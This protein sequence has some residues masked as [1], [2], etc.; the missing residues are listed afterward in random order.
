M[1]GDAHNHRGT[2][3]SRPPLVAHVWTDYVP[4]SFVEPHSHM[5]S[6]EPRF[7]SVNLVA[8]LWDNGKVIDAHT[9]WMFR[10][11]C[12]NLVA[13]TLLF[14]VYRRATTF[15]RRIRFREFVLEKASGFGASLIHSHFGTTGCKLNRLIERTGWPHV[16]TLYGYDGSAALLSRSLRRQYTR[17]YQSASRIVVLCETVKQRLIATGCAPGKIVVWNMP[18]GIENFPYRP[19][20][21]KK[22]IRIL[23]AAR[24]VE[25]KG[26]VYLLEAFAKVARKGHPVRLVLV[27]YGNLTAQI[28]KKIEALGLRSYVSLIDNKL[29][30]DFTSDYRS[31]LNESDIFV[32]PSVT[33]RN[34]TDEAGPALSMVC[35][36]AAGLPV[37]CTP[38]PGSEISLVDG[39]TGLYCKERDAESLAERIEYLLDRPHLW[40]ELG[41][42]GSELVHREFAEKTQMEKLYRIYEE[43]LGIQ[44]RPEKPSAKPATK[45]E[46]GAR[47]PMFQMG[48]GN[49]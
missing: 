14:R 3:G 41:R 21:P 43:A 18:A 16:V 29:I 38:F 48:A 24:F 11:S 28:E 44:P 34:G 27:G 5:V 13:P 32:L 22:Q 47:P 4:D 2:Q 39:V 35:A 1:A 12:R 37:I 42:K 33:D 36:Q 49:A 8:N 9:Y 23:M 30:G 46:P 25:A 10:R 6:G 40:N 17:M 7:R 20:A 45:P 19:R 31:L 26:H 15:W